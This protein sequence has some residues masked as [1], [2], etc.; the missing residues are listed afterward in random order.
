MRAAF[1]YHPFYV[2]L[3]PAKP[4]LDIVGT[5]IFIPQGN[6]DQFFHTSLKEAMGACH[7]QGLLLLF[8]VGAST[9]IM[10]QKLFCQKGTFTGIQEDPANT[11]NWTSEKVEACDNGVLC[12]ETILLVKTAGTKT[13]ILAT[14]SCSLDGTPAITYIRH[15]ADPGLVAI[16]YS[17]YCE[18]P[19]CNNREGLYD[20]WNIQETKEETKG[21]TGLRCPTCL[22]V[23]S[24][25]NAPSLAC[26]NDTD[27]CYQGKL[28]ISEGN[29]NSLLEVKGCTSIIGCRLMSGVF[30]IGPLWVKETCPFMSISTRKIDSGATWL[31]TSVWKLKLLLMLLLL[32]LGGSA[33][34]P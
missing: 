27:R 16:S 22:A 28:Q 7:F 2:L 5:Q 31:H 33:S 13:A 18:D 11:F 29:V 17:N 4:P 10:A 24:C 20:I 9:L 32:V 3:P 14:K 25:L 8:L 15:A 1:F 6:P 34:G 23:G 21:T 30:K 12:Q 19:F 26:P